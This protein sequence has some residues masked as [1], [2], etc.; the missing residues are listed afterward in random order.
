MIVTIFNYV[1]QCL[2][3]S[4][5][6]TFSMELYLGVVRLGESTQRLFRLNEFVDITP[7]YH[8]GEI[9]Q[10][11]VNRLSKSSMYCSV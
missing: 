5:Y 9:L 11:I 6:F 8:L 7:L 4:T 2:V 3:F 10:R 1:D